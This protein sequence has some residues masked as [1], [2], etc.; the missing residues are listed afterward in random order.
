MGDVVI[1]RA[2]DPIGV[3]P[4]AFDGA[5]TSTVAARRVGMLADF[6]DRVRES[7]VQVLRG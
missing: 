5:G 6:G 3:V 2:F 7:V 4:G 1:G